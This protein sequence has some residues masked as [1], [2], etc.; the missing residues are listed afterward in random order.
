LFG[1]DLRPRINASVSVL[2]VIPCLKLNVVFVTIYGYICLLFYGLGITA[3]APL[4]Q[5][6]RAVF[7][8]EPV[9][10]HAWLGVS[11][12][13]GITDYPLAVLQSI[14][15]GIRFDLDYDTVFFWA[16]LPLIS[17]AFRR[18]LNLLRPQTR[19]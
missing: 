5:T 1:F 19:H 17:Y 11:A 8:F 7:P 3:V 12:S 14:L 16:G 13:F 9:H 4:I 10:I 2:Q 15:S 6:F 18:F